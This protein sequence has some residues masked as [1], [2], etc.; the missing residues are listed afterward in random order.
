MTA[1]EAGRGATGTVGIAPSHLRYPTIEDLRRRARRRVPRFAFDYADAGCGDDICRDENRR[2][3]DALKFVP[4]YGRG[5]PSVSLDVTLFGRR[6]AAPMGIAPMGLGGLVWPGCEAILARAAQAARIPYILATPAGAA[7]QEI[8][9]LAPDVFWFQLYGAPRDDHRITFDLVRR[10]ESAGAPVLV[11]TIDSPVRGKRPRDL[12]NR[13]SVPFRPNIATILDVARSPAWAREVLLAG[14]PA[15]RNFIPYADGASSAGALAGVVERELRGG[16]TWDTVRRVRDLWP[17]ALVVKGICSVE[18]AEE[19]IASGADGL[20]VS[21]HGG[22]AFDGAPAAIEL[23]PPVVEAVGGRATILHDSGIRSGLDAV[24]AFALGAEA[25]L[26]GRPFLYGVAALGSAGGE[27]VVEF[28]RSEI[29][30]ALGQL[31]VTSVADAG[32]SLKLW[33]E[34]SLDAESLYAKRPKK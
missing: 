4:S 5:A 34:A 31:G 28:Y 13:L 6:Y 19:A 17:R 7:I 3:L 2:A 25:V 21:N 10:A 30:A 26:A 18:D 22:R 1:S 29:A 8:A 11:V 27:H 14:I 15:C 16:F 20:V 9:P 32:R 12:R 24:R 33:K 23:L